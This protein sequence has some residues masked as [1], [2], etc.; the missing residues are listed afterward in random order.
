MVVLE[1]KTVKDK[2]LKLLVLL[3]VTMLTFLVLVFSTSAQTA[4]FI[5]LGMQDI[6]P[7]DVTNDGSM[8]LACNYLGHGTFLWQEETGFVLVAANVVPAGI[9]DDGKIVGTLYW[10]ETIEGVVV[11][12]GSS[13]YY[14]DG[15]WINIGS[16]YGRFLDREESFCQGINS[17][18][19]HIMAFSWVPEGTG[20]IGNR[21]EACFW[22]EEDE[23]TGLG[24]VYDGN[25]RVDAASADGSII[26]GWSQQWN[27]CQR[28]YR[29]VEN[30]Q[31]DYEHEW[32]GT[33][34]WNPE[35]PHGKARSV[36]DNGEYIA[37]W[38]LSEN[39][40]VSAFV[41][42]EEDGMV[43][44][45]NG[46][47]GTYS[48]LA[49]SV[50][51]NGTF[52]GSYDYGWGGVRYAF[53]G[54]SPDNVV[55]LQ[56]SL[57]SLGTELPPGIHI[58]NAQSISS[59]GRFITGM[60]YNADGWIRPYLVRFN[61][62]VPEYPAMAYISPETLHMQWEYSSE[63]P[64]AIL[65]LELRYQE[66]DSD[67]WGEYESISEPL[68][69]DVSSFDY[70]I[71]SFGRYQFRIAAVSGGNQSDWVESNIVIALDEPLAAS[72]FTAE[73]ENSSSTVNLSW[74]D[75]ANNEV[76]YRLEK[77]EMDDDG[78]W[79]D[80][81][82]L[83]ILE[84]DVESYEDDDVVWETTYGY[85]I[86][87]ENE[88]GE[89][90]WAETD[91]LFTG[92]GEFTDALPTESKITGNYPNPF[93]GTT[94]ISF[95]IHKKSFVQMKLYSIDGRQLGQPVSANHV[96]GSHQ[97]TLNLEHLATGTYFLRMEGDGI[98]SIRKIVLLK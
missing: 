97:V 61:I 80:W 55:S 93:N 42:T 79:S 33:F 47:E 2:S 26:V 13:A 16:L 11:E 23:W 60:Y 24:Q 46:L 39:E 17:T 92:V 89:S 87:A 95:D 10:E 58:Y 53:I 7:I 18:G 38:S 98:T 66:F 69:Y 67:E 5:D 14:E 81:A 84:A 41:W 51:D 28:A 94:T 86:R 29:W 4:E 54:T 63:N 52:V 25:S 78:N 40:G 75:N 77:C 19:S 9:S 8:V 64:E 12:R 57:I 56:D 72:D 59:D 88:A 15:E 21:A 91:L 71:E 96:A 85:R 34:S 74:V 48:S 6:Y 49:T 31:G 1:D 43:N 68:A 30:E 83:D 82:D 76:L 32:L 44:I 70:T 73:I 90:D 22:T 37:G 20:T 35:W 45:G 3:V 36:S 50:S 27:G 65:L 62:A